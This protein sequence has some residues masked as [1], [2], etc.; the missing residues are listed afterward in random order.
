M[1]SKKNISILGSTGSIGKSTLKVINKN[2]NKVNI[3][4]LSANKNYKLL[5]KQ[6]KIFKVKNLVIHDFKSYLEAKKKLKNKNLKLFPDISEYLKINKKKIDYKIKD[7]S[8]LEGLLPTI[9][10]IPFTKNLSSAN[11]ESIICGWEFIKKQLIKSKTNFI[12]ID[13]EHFSIWSLLKKNT[14][15][16]SKVYLTASGGP[17][18][19]KK[20]NRKKKINIKNVTNHPNWSM[21]KKISTDSATLMNKVFEVIEASKIFNINKKKIEI[22]IH[23]KSIIHAIVAFNNGLVKLLTHDTTMEI[24]I[25]NVIFGNDRINYYDKAKLNFHELNGVNFVHPDKK[26]FPYINILKRR[27][28]NNSYFDTIIVTLNDELVKLFLN[29]KL[30]FFKMQRIL[31]KSISSKDFTKYFNKYPKKINDIFIM[32]DKVKNYLKKNEKNIF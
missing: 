20:Y 1:V 22:I 15:I 18:L 28:T 8:G 6:A 7:I 16:I 31:L 2:F 9:E 14:D 29:K 27:K 12:P 13:S 19:E 11:K 30:S 24:P 5:F 10:I 3:V 26:K 32:A 23:P 25:F 17:F 21:G 4:L